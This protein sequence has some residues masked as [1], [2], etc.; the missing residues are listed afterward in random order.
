MFHFLSF[1]IV[2]YLS[3][4]PLNTY[5]HTHSSNTYFESGFSSTN[6]K[7]QLP[8]PSPRWG[9][10]TSSPSELHR[11]PKYL[12]H[13][14]SP[15]KV[16]PLSLWN[17]LHTLVMPESLLRVLNTPASFW[18]TNLHDSPFSILL[19]SVFL[20]PCLRYAVLKSQIIIFVLYPGVIILPLKWNI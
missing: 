1:W 19:I 20:Y 11:Q 6:S 13:W 8:G 4:F 16:S 18:L 17:I 3:C 10:A 12:S 5:T 14:Y 15:G 9:W 7:S 2:L